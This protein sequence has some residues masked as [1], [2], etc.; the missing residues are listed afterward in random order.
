MEPVVRYLAANPL[1]L[2]F[3]VL[4]VGYPLGRIKLGGASLGLSAV[5]FAGIL[6]G[7]WDSRLRLPEAIGD[8]GL[9]VFMYGL[10]LVSARGLG[11]AFTRRG[12]QINAV[13][14]G[15][16]L[17]AA[18]ASLGL[19]R[20]LG[21][22]PLSMA[23]LFSGSASSASSL[24]SVMDLARH[25]GLSADGGEAVVAYSITSPL[26]MLLPM[27]AFLVFRRLAR[28]DLAAEARAMPGFQPPHARPEVWTILVSRPEA[29]GLTKREVRLRSG[30]HFTFGRWLRE[31]SYV[32]PDSRSRL[33]LGDLVAVVGNPADLV[34]VQALLGSR[35]AHEIDRKGYELFDFFR[36]FVSEESIV[37][38][39]LSEL[40]LPSRFQG[41]I[42]RV[43]RGETV[44]VPCGETVLELG[45][46][47]GMVARRENR[48]FFA[49]LFGDSY[50][51]ISEVDFLT[52][53]LGLGLGLVVGQIPV[54]LPGGL[55]FR[56]GLGGGPLLVALVLGR[57]RRVGRWHFSFP[58][59]ASLALRQFGLG[60][61]F[62]G[63][64][65]VAGV[66]L[67]HA[68][69]GGALGLV[70]AGAALSLLVSLL[71]MTVGYALARIP[72]NH[73][74]GI[75][76]GAQTN[77]AILAFMEEQCGN[78]LPQ[79][80]YAAVYPFAIVAKIVMAQALLLL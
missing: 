69:E 20:W 43:R 32:I 47:V 21:L 50:R 64:G 61:F 27:A 41:I 55:S 53:S 74:G 45:D 80:T 68:P 48:A 52:F 26:A 59:S 17:L 31:G 11:A 63:A 44:F 76:A 29:E 71:V 49:R 28:V 1:V 42:T 78:E 58:Y 22:P 35:S 23:G 39:P 54:P 37:G 46:R 6:F 77:S 25:A 60:L 14:L 24:A 33:H 3:A 12:L 70:L 65:T 73:L 9:A 57:F 18:L 40:R 7:Y 19:G 34:R 72:L 16:L 62:A 38:R 36:F 10:G 13:A 15:A 79:D 2:L 67:R 51:A 8:L 5:L 30:A 4:A 66:A 56:L 75:L